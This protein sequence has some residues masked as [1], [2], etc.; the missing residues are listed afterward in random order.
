LV[1]LKGQDAFADNHRELSLLKPSADIA[2]VDPD[3]RIIGF[4]RSHIKAT[5]LEAEP[6][7]EYLVA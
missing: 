1:P 2:T 6:S 5:V 4:L 3:L 7:F